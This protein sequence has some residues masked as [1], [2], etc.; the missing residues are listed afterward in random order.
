MGG[1]NQLNNHQNRAHAKRSG[2][3]TINIY[4]ITQGFGRQKPLPREWTSKHPVIHTIPSKSVVVLRE[5]ERE[6]CQGG[7]DTEYYIFIIIIMI[8]IMISTGRQN[9]CG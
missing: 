8:M 2:W 3:S 7:A 9:P 1:S 6:R 4:V 5:R